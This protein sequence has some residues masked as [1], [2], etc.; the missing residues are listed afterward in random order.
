MPAPQKTI[1][2]FKAIRTNCGKVIIPYRDYLAITTL[3]R[4]KSLRE[5][6]RGTLITEI[7]ALVSRLRFIKSKKTEIL[8]RLGMRPSAQVIEDPMPKLRA[9]PLPIRGR[10][11]HS[12]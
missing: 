2:G 7:E 8:C 11:K 10:I 9:A 4:Q 12:R 1:R 6:E 5:T 3:E